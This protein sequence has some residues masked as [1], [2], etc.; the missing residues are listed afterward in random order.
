MSDVDERITTLQAAIWRL[1]AEKLRLSD[2]ISLAA[3][4]IRALQS[5]K[6]VSERASILKTVPHWSE[7]R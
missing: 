6:E 2:A 5:K 3:S 1:Y 4:E 7:G